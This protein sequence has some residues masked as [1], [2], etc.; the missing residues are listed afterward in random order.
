LPYWPSFWPELQACVV[1]VSWQ[2]Y[3]YGL[4]D[5]PV[6]TTTHLGKKKQSKEYYLSE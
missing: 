1:T 3:G 5:D 2:K 4:D 6:L